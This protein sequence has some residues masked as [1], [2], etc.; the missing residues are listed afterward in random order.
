MEFERYPRRMN[1]EQY[2][3]AL[4][5]FVDEMDASEILQIPGVYE[6]ISRYF[7]E[8]AF[9]SDAY[10]SPLINPGFHEAGAAPASRNLAL[11]MRQ[12]EE[13]IKRQLLTALPPGHYPVRGLTPALI[14]NLAA[15]IVGNLDEYG[16]ED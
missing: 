14:R 12:V 8:T 13:T 6:R 5:D 2:M 7:Q 10:V 1:H 11:A 9:A 16:R 15:Q 4:F 3:E